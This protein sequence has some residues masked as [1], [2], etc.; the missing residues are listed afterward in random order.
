MKRSAELRLA[1]AGIG[2]V[3][4]AIALRQAGFKVQS[5]SRAEELREI[6]VTCCSRQ[7]PKALWVS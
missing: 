2:G 3:T 7:R 6:G 4:A 1:G 5:S